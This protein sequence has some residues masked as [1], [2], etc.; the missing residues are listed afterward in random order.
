MGMAWTTFCCTEKETGMPNYG[1]T[2]G[3]VNQSFFF[4]GGEVSASPVMLADW[5]IDTEV[6][7]PGWTNPNDATLWHWVIDPNTQISF[8]QPPLTGSS[9]ISISDYLHKIHPIDAAQLGDQ[10]PLT[11]CI[12][13]CKRARTTRV[14]LTYEG[15][16][17]AEA[18]AAKIPPTRRRTACVK[19]KRRARGPQPGSL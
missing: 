8:G 6:Y 3:E 14:R 19:P 5:L 16:R 18:L 7:R 17:I 2:H 4:N 10:S 9:S 13:G 12:R 15:H 11:E 1:Q